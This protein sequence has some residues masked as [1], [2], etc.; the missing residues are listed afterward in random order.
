MA[1]IMAAREAQ[2]KTDEEDNLTSHGNQKKEPTGS[3]GNSKKALQA[4]PVEQEGGMGTIEQD[5]SNEELGANPNQRSPTPR[6]KQDVTVRNKQEGLDGQPETETNDQLPTSPKTSYHDWVAYEALA[7]RDESDLTWDERMRLEQFHRRFNYA[8]A[9]PGASYGSIPLPESD[10]G[11]IT[12]SSTRVSRDG[13]MRGG[14]GR[15]SSEAQRSP[16]F[17]H[18]PPTFRLGQP[19]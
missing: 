10:I 7:D 9:M 17:S 14:A 1:E 5:I 3:V 15:T 11:T 6:N 2:K 16:S 19:V 8:M 18:L 4:Q 13:G 12:R